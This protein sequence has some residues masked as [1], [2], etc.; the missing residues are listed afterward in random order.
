MKTILT[1]ATLLS[2]ATTAYTQ[3][4]FENFKKLLSEKDTLGERNLLAEWKSKNDND[5]E[6]YTSY[7]NYYVQ[8][9]ISDIIRLDG[10]PG[11]RESVTVTDSTNRVVG[12]IY[13][14]TRYNPKYLDLG[15]E[16]ID[17]GIEKFPN[18]LDM[19]FGKI[20]MLGQAKSFDA[21]TSEIVR[22][23][24]YSVINKDQWQWTMNEPVDKPKDSSSKIFRPI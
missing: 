17:K 12:Y 16:S 11:V 9:S 20:H 24:N 22:S 18:R 19:R 21:F 2:F 14:E 7:F 1:I 23:I 13:G 10:N 15:F 8:K 4:Y 5:P 6:L 3:D